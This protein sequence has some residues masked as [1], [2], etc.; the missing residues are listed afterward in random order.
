MLTPMFLD[1]IDQR[2]F[3]HQ[4]RS[5]IRLI[6]ESTYAEIA[7]LITLPPGEIF[8]A[9]QTGPRVVSLTREGATA[10]QGDRIR[11]IV[12]PSLDVPVTAIAQHHLRATLFHELHHLA[13]GWTRV[14]SGPRPTLM[15]AVIS[16]GL[17]TAF[18]RDHGGRHSPWSQYPPEVPEWVAELMAQD[19]NTFRSPWMFNHPDGRRWI[20]YRAGVYLVD[21]V[22][23]R[24]R[25]DHAEL[26][27][28]S[29]ADLL[30]NAG[31]LVHGSPKGS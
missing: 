15:D 6:C 23:E 18:E 28:C 9:C 10:L 21:R 3:D 19:P 25:K 17:A 5:D 7:K 13:R 22:I 31:Y 29:T 8:V 20:G 2:F 11:W 30:S 24:T 12:N 26:L 16:E 1:T 14:R 4:S 27:H